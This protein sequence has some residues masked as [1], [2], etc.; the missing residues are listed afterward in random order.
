MT[1]VK[2][3]QRETTVYTVDEQRSSAH[4]V[5]FTHSSTS[6]FRPRANGDKKSESKKKTRHRVINIVANC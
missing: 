6:Y 5:S 3:V 2:T 1:S 4:Q